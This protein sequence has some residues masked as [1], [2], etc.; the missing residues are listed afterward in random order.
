MT[1]VELP[2]LVPAE[3]VDGWNPY[4]AAWAAFHGRTPDEKSDR[5]KGT[6]HL[7]VVWISGEWTVFAAEHGAA[8]VQD[9]T[10]AVKAGFGAW[11]AERN[12]AGA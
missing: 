4:Y 3:P 10:P 1:A 12:G 2:F 8:S 6:G 11:L 5:D 9:L 7:F